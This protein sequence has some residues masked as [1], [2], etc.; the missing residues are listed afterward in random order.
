MKKMKTKFI[1]ILLAAVIIAP[2]YE[3]PVQA[4][5]G[6]ATGVTLLSSS[7]KGIELLAETT[8]K[9]LN[10]QT[11]VVDGEQYTDIT[12]Q[13]W[14]GLDRP[15]EPNLPFISAMIAVPFGVDLTLEFTPG[16]SKVIQLEAPVMPGK[17]QIL[18][19][20]H[21]PMLTDPMQMEFDFLTQPSSHIYASGSLYP[22]E[23]VQ[24]TNDGVLRNQRLVSIAFFPVQY[25]PQENTITV[26]E[27]I[28]ASVKFTGK[29]IQPTTAREAPDTLFDS[30]LSKTLL[31]YDNAKIWRLNG[32]QIETEPQIDKEYLEA[33]SSS[34]PWQPP[35]PAWRILTESSG[36]F[37]LDYDDLTA[38]GVLLDN[39]NPKNF[40]LFHQGLELAIEVVGEEDDVFDTQ[41]Q[42]LF[43]A[44]DFQSKY[45]KFDALWLT[46]GDTPGLRVEPRTGIAP[47]G[48]AVTGYKQEFWH[49]SNLYYTSLLKGTDDFERFVGEYI[50]AKESV[51]ASKSLILPFETNSLAVGPAD[52]NLRVFGWNYSDTLNPDHHIRVYLNEV[53]VGEAYWD[54]NNWLEL[55]LDV[56]DLLFNGSNILRLELPIDLGLNYEVVYLDWF[57]LYYPRN[58]RAVSDHLEYAYQMPGDWLFSLEGF[59]TNDREYLRIWDISSAINPVKISDFEIITQEPANYTLTFGDEILTEK[60]YLATDR[61]N[62]SQV[63]SIE[64]DTFGKLLNPTIPPQMIIISPADFL[65]EAGRL[66]DYRSS[67]GIE[68]MAVDVQDVYDAFSFGVISVQAIKQY[69]GFALEQWNTQYVLLLG[70]GHYDPKN[71]LGD[72]RTNY[73][74]AFLAYVDPYIGE[75][76][77]D[78]RYVD[79][80]GDDLLPDMMLGRLTVNTL[81][82][83]NRVVNKIISYEESSPGET[84]AY[85]ILSVADDPDGGG[86]FPQIADNLFDDLKPENYMLDKVHYMVT[87]TDPVAVRAAIVDQMNSGKI[88]VNYI[89]HASYTI[90]G[91]EPLFSREQVWLLTN[92]DRLSINL[93]LSCMDGFFHDPSTNFAHKEGLA[94][95]VTRS[96]DAGAIASWSPTGMGIVTGHD[97][98]DRGFL[99]AYFNLGVASLGEATLA[100]KVNLWETG[101]NQDLLDTYTLFGD[102]ALRLHHVFSAIPDSYTVAEDETLSISAENGVI[103]NDLNPDERSLIAEIFVPTSH[104]EVSLNADGSFIY[105]PYPNYFGVDSFEYK[106][107][108]GTSHSNSTKVSITVT[109]VND[110]PV[111]LNQLVWTPK[112][113]QLDIELKAIDDGGSGPYST[114]GNFD[115]SAGISEDELVFS[116]VTQ[117]L[118]GML[119][120]TPPFMTYTP[121]NDFV[122][123][124]Q[125][126]F[127]ANDGQFDSNIAQVDIQVGFRNL[128]L[129]LILR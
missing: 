72:G 50:Y 115:E 109:A 33:N 36:I 85:S 88:L 90:W 3:H 98:L 63:S 94:E 97:Y 76:A 128:F 108:D 5:G 125:F 35:A 107:F 58:T 100:G 19:Q 99:N 24:I 7:E 28:V 111:A 59:T 116:I 104:G 48:I 68:A 6:A 67:V 103:A 39:P 2:V 11:T 110:P 95:T 56:T 61:R 10:L 42:I 13:G 124:D 78:N 60:H 32:A 86:N 91:D 14:T 73:I 65:S 83:A 121:V 52:L 25:N 69:L 41:D 71:H 17:T 31:N 53:F 117:P 40:S 18:R 84:W 46:I 112:N 89:G 79:L 82:E 70:D 9:D 1:L 55:N 20:E 57:T 12:L 80:V 75:T 113:T 26:F 96:T 27:S 122:G 23:L 81:S 64:L 126:T 4:L 49:E 43:Y 15:G 8:L 119:S 101:S 62:A 45:T 129:P 30:Y 102:P 37:A 54:G 123:T 38:A 22:E 92:T 118:H 77:A 29:I 16:S 114:L 105:A 120:G 34:L 87:H 106:L 21:D 93:T 127:K 74:P 51:P 44:P 66:A 47:T